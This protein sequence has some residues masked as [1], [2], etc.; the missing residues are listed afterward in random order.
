MH[1]VMD[2]C[3]QYLVNTAGARK[4]QPV[5][6]GDQCFLPAATRNHRYE[7]RSAKVRYANIWVVEF[8]KVLDA[9]MQSILMAL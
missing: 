1:P 7:V 4:F 8:G 2:D 3:D 5:K 6:A 9:T